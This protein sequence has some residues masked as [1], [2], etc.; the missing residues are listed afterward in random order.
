MTAASGILHKEYHAQEFSRKGGIFQMVQLWVNLPAKDKMSKPKY[1]A[2]TK[3]KMGV[4]DLG[5]GSY[6][7]V[8]A[9]EFAGVKGPA[10]TFTPIEM[11]NLHLKK[12]VS[13]D[14]KL[15]ADFNTG[16][17]VVEGNVTINSDEKAPTN[18]FI[19]F[20]NDGEDVNVQADDDAVVLVLSG[21][22]IDEPITSY[23][24]FVMNTQEEIREAF[25]DYNQGKFGYLE[26]D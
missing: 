17:L 12:D 11:Y 2:I 8:I 16:F 19:L 24:P 5:N 18:H 4:H 20:K 1:Q 25:D 3:D 7:E 23:G 21:Q 10:S 6:A 13:V 14:F 9:G 22:T 26:E 15:P